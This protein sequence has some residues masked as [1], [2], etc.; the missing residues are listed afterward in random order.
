MSVNIFKLKFVRQSKF[1]K[2]CDDTEWLLWENSRDGGG[3]GYTVLSNI[4]K[5][6]AAPAA[7]SG[8]K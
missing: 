3:G 6:P 4:D 1:C 7:F 5:V 2:F 8:E